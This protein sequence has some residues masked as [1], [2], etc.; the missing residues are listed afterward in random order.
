EASGH[1]SP[2][3]G[4]GTTLLAA[5][6][7]DDHVLVAHVGDSRFYRLRNDKLSRLTHDHS[8]VQER[9]DSG[10]IS[11]EAARCADYRNLLTRA[12]GV[13]RQVE[14]EL[15]VHQTE[16]NDVYLLCSDGLYDM[17]EESE[18]R[19]TLLSHAGDLSG[20]AGT[21]IELANEYGGE[22][23]ISVVVVKVVQKFPASPK[24]WSK[25]CAWF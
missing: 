14:P 6:F 16:L 7:C 4:M 13:D 21:L 17:I 5:I 9:L 15:H 20:A 12:V 11:A 8:L 1:D 23:N 3:F 2:F 24:S 10:M 22:D 18:I 25:L 19:R